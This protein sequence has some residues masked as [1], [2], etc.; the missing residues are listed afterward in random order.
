ML[1]QI[2]CSRL[3]HL[4]FRAQS[5]LLKPSTKFWEGQI[6]YNRVLALRKSLWSKRFRCRGSDLFLNCLVMTKRDKNRMLNQLGTFEGR[7]LYGSVIRRNCKIFALSRR[8]N[9]QATK[10]SRNSSVKRRKF[11][12]TKKQRRGMLKRHRT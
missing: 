5:Q 11:L 7:A 8:V 10:I 12:A 1:R 9:R 6:M 3:V 4:L 2:L